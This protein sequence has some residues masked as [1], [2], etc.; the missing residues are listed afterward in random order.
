MKTGISAFIFLFL[1]A[2]DSLAQMKKTHETVNELGGQLGFSDQNSKSIE[3]GVNYYW[4]INNDFACGKLHAHNF[5]PFACGEINFVKGI[6]YIGEKAGFNY[7]FNNIYSVQISP[8]VEHFAKKDFRVGGDVGV[9]LLGIY[10]Y[11]G[12][13]LPI[14]PEKIPGTSPSRFGVRLV[15]NMAPVETTPF[16]E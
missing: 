8:T 9:S 2:N 12:Y 3:F 1:F 10:A 7:H 5:G 14:G 13:Y 16:G 6:T 11:Y 4:S 15:F